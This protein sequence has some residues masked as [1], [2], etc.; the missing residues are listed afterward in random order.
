MKPTNETEAIMQERFGKDS[1]IALAT[2]E[3]DLPSVRTVDA[4]YEDGCFYVLTYALSSKMKQI[5]ANP[6]VAI[7]GEW[8]TARGIGENL[9]WFCAQENARLA[10]KMRQLFAAWIDNGHNHFDDPNTCILRIRL[11]N[12]VLLAHG[13]RYS[14]EYTGE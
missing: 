6:V 11:T 2:L 12:A 1:L 10:N 5:A 3:G 13:E 14:I 8:F 9:G 7:C 4:F